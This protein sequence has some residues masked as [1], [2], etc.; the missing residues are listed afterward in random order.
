MPVQAVS[1]GADCLNILPPLPPGCNNPQWVDELHYVEATY[2]SGCE[3]R[4]NVR[5]RSCTYF[6]PICGKTRTVVQFYVGGIDWIIPDPPD[7]FSPCG[8]LTKHL[9][10][11]WPNDFDNVRV[12]RLQELYKNIQEVLADQL[13]MDH[14]NSL[15]LL[16]QQTMHCAPPDCQMPVE[17]SAFTVHYSM[18][19]CVAFCYS[20]CFIDGLYHMFINQMSCTDNL[21]CCLHTRNYCYC[22]ATEQIK[23]VESINTQIGSCESSVF[24]PSMCPV[25]TPNCTWR[26]ATDCSINCD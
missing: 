7:I 8:Q 4:I 22:P 19:K 26:A 5:K 20:Q 24:D 10:P 9:F 25:V 6:D 2:F 14:Y 12:D 13:F 16:D 15:N 3:I 17:C 11:G 18:P 1:Q 21:V 23:V